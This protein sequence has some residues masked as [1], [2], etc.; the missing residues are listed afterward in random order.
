MAIRKVISNFWAL[1][2]C[3]PADRLWEVTKGYELFLNP[4]YLAWRVRHLI[5][6]LETDLPFS[7]IEKKGLITNELVRVYRHLLTQDWRSKI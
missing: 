7:R 4:L 3:I 2:D 5:H 6:M 1:E